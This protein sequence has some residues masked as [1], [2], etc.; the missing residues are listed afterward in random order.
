MDDTVLQAA[1]LKHLSIH[2]DDSGQKVIASFA[3]QGSADT[4]TLDEFKRVIDKAGFGGHSLHTPAVE[5][6]V[7]KYNSGEAFEIVIGEAVDGKFSLKADQMNAYLTY[8]LPRGGVPAQMKSILLEAEK[9]G[10]TVKLDLEAIGKTLM[11]GGYNVVVASG[12]PP[13]HGMD[14]RFESLIPSIKDRSP[15]LDEHG[16]AD[17]RDLG[18]IVAV[19]PGDPLMRRILP[20]SGVPGQTLA[21]KVIP[22]KPGKKVT[23]ATKLEGAIVS[24]HDPDLLVSQI[25]GIPVLLK[26]G[27]KVEPVYAVKNVDLHT[28]N[29][30]FDGTLHVAGDIRAG[31]TVKTSGD[32]HVDGTVEGAMLDAGGDIVVE[33]GIIGGTEQHIKPGEKFQPLIKCNGSCT[34]RFAQNAH[35][36]A[37]QGIFIHDNAML[38]ELTAG[39]QIIVGDDGS[40][41]G[42]IIGGVARAAMLIKTQNLGSDDNVRTVV[43][44][45]ADKILHERLSIAAKTREA[46]E[47]ELS[48]IIKILEIA[49]LKPGRVPP[50]TIKA[51]L[52]TRDVLNSQIESSREDERELR[53]QIDLTSGAQ[54]VV[55]KHIYSGAEIHLGL[56][57]YEAV[58][59]R[60]GGVFHLKDGDLVFD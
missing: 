37:G 25:S 27:V 5:K 13:V 30:T 58:Q 50:E 57:R 29:I 59:D 10:I 23:F 40:R 52:A 9:K 11:E 33:G 34:A 44:A 36:S 16:L 8:T 32:I 24:P 45:G 28:G 31:M 55:Q 41:K 7:E 4:V 1:H 42:N 14:G 39:H 15:H 49:R 46:M 6:A 54:V 26:D 2:L 60:E 43:F 19:H 12:T 21:G 18:E 17:F 22:A 53:R 56:K 20:T 3:P 47:K 38:S 35:I 48:D 51:V